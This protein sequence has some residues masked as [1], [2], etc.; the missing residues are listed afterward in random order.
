MS[1]SRESATLRVPGD[2]RLFI[3][4]QWMAPS[5]AGSI[6][7]V[8][9]FTAEVV[10]TVPAPTTADADRAVQAAR[11]AFDTGPWPWMP[12]SDR[13]AVVRR[14]CDEIEARMEDLNL[15]WTVENGVTVATREA[16]NNV[17]AKVAWDRALAVAED[18]S[19]SEIRE[20]AGFG[21]VEIRREPA[22]V[23]LAV[24][25]YNGPVVLLAL[26]IVPALLAGCPVIVKPAPESQ[27][28]ARLVADAAE[29]ADFP[30]GVFSVLAAGNE[31][32]SHLSA[33]PG[34]DLVNFTGGT[35]IGRSVM[36]SCSARIARCILEL[37]GKSAGIVADDV[38]IDDL[39]PRLL[40]GMLAQQGQV[41]V[42]TTRILV[43]RTRHDEVVE[44]LAETLRAQR[45][46]DPRDPET[47]WGPLA[48]E[49]A[50]DRAEVFTA[51][52]L[53]EGAKLITGGRR[54]DDFERGWFFEP[55]LFAEVD[56]SMTIAQEEVFGPL[57]SVIPYSDIDDAVRIAN[58]SKYGL[59]G[60]VFTDDQSLALDVA[61]RV[62]TGIFTINSGGACLT[63]PY[64]GMKQSGIGRESGLEGLLEHTEV[65][66]IMLGD[67]SPHL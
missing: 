22:G 38:S 7:V 61:R 10:T 58:D 53:Q 24:I 37:G 30:S 50:R 3:G 15:A 19:F 2:D 1:L 39:L 57:Y 21:P 60:A 40:P 5:G 11:Q 48:V 32:S 29:V 8:S 27:L 28:V 63:E 65:K 6:D 51:Q 54:P 14:F 41:C 16:A 44:A 25:T 52:A 31:V 59:A 42:S 17:V 46:G 18:V 36:A 13:I 66:T 26:K 12:M 35:G 64:G 34:V 49:R 56:N 4:G 55:T 43:S 33:H 20:A 23:V 45:I 62:R 9:P 47:E 67:M